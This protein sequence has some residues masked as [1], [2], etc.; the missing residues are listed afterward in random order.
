MKIN[1]LTSA[2]GYP[3]A[4]KEKRDGSFAKHYSD[5][6]ANADE[7]RLKK[8]NSNEKPDKK[9][10][11][12]AIDAFQTDPQAQENGLKASLSGNG[13]GLK[14]VLKDG[15]GSIVRQFTGEEFLRL[16]QSVSKDDRICGKILDQKL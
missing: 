10:I 14:V 5:A 12:E 4:I 2:V 9:K 13:P 11:D 16:R 6:E 1:S 7:E 3:I 8:E 15:Q